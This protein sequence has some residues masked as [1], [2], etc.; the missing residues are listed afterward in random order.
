MT[1]TLMI[2]CLLMLVS[3]IAGYAMPAAIGAALPDSG[4]LIT[5]TPTPTPNLTYMTLGDAEIAIDSNRTMNWEAVNSSMITNPP[6]GGAGGSPVAMAIIGAGGG[7][8]T[9]YNSSPP[10]PTPTIDP[11]NETVADLFQQ[12]NDANG[13]TM[14]AAKMVIVLG[15][16]GVAFVVLQ[17][18]GII[19]AFSHGRGREQP[20]ADD[21]RGT[22]AGGLTIGDEDNPR[23]PAQS[24]Q[25]PEK[26]EKKPE[27]RDRYEVIK[28]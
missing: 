1:N 17:Q 6:P 2:F 25:P 20:G 22:Y 11:A 23:Q 5:A 13:V 26:E 10:T 14:T 21:G 27:K 16:S 4:A 7:P 9:I 8:A 12:V 24:T 19:P 28:V 3:Y 15:V 18:M